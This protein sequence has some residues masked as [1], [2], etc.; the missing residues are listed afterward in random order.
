MCFPDMEEQERQSVMRQHYRDMA[1]GLFETCSAWWK[2]IEHMP[3]FRIEG[4]EYLQTLKEQKKGA[5]LLTAHFT[6]L[7]I[8]GRFLSESWSICGLYRDPNNPV[9]AQHMKF[10]RDNCMSEA[11]DHENLRGL[12]RA[13]RS[14]EHVWYASDQAKRTPL[15]ILSTFFGHP[16]VTTTATSRIC[17]MSGAVVVPYFAKR[18]EDGSYLLQISAPL[19]N[20]PSED[21][22]A[23]TRRINAIFETNIEQALS[24]YFWMHKRFKYR[25]PDFPS[26]Y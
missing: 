14:G 10:H 7:E 11:I 17:D 5:L 4:L 20:F 26:P 19:E 25:E 13:L 15:S 3:P 1:I 8:C 22:V 9:I 21:V 6:T 23:D 24:Q 2:K 16:A 12:L 18:C